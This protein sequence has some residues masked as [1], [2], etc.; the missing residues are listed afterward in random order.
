M[1][2]TATSS[3]WAQSSSVRSRRY[4]APVFGRAGGCTDLAVITDAESSSGPAATRGASASDWSSTPST[5]KARCGLSGKSASYAA[6]RG[7]TSSARGGRA[8]R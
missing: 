6:T 5:P 7:S 4:S 2:A 8:S 3:R 1:Q